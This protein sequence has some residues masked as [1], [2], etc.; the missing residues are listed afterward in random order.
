VDLIAGNDR[1]DD[2]T[3]KLVAAYDGGVQRRDRAGKAPRKVAE[4]AAFLDRLPG[5][6]R[7]LEV[8]AGTGTDS[9]FF[10]EHGLDVVAA[11]LSPA[12]VASCRE[13][14]IDARVMDFLHLDFPPE[15]ILAR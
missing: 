3:K 6:A 5:G 9:L 15:A 7:L 10:Q 14:G 1:Y 12:M 13:K 4:R 8:G 11:D 2:I